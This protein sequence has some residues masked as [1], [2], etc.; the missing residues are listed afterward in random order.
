MIIN[1]NFKTIEESSLYQ[2][3]IH[4]NENMVMYFE[5][6]FEFDCKMRW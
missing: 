6:K 3:K 1:S 2:N 4:I 5:L